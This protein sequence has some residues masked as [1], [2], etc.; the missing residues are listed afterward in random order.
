MQS[1]CAHAF[2]S[3][4]N[5]FHRGADGIEQLTKAAKRR[6]DIAE[7]LLHVEKQKASAAL[8]RLSET[9][10]IL[11]NRYLRV[12][13]SEALKRLEKICDPADENFIDDVGK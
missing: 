2:S 5:A 11:R 6:N 3:Q 7:Q 9:S 1:N 4:A 12:P 10:A 13:Q 8:F